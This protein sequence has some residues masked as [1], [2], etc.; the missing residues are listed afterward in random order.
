[1]MEYLRF[2]HLMRAQLV[3]AGLMS[4]SACLLLPATLPAASFQGLGALAGGAYFYSRPSDISADGHVIVG[5]SRSSNGVEAFRWTAT[6]AMVGLG[7]LGGESFFSTAFGVSANGSV[8]VGASRSSTSGSRAEA[9]RWAAATGMVGLGDLPGGDY[10][11][12]A[13]GVSGDGSVV[14][15]SS[16]SD[17]SPSW[18]E[19]FRWTEATGLVGLGVLPGSEIPTSVTWRIS[20]DGRVVVGWASTGNGRE[21]FRWTD[22]EGMI[23]MGDLPGALFDSWATGVSADGSVIVGLA[24]GEGPT[25]FRWTAATGMVDLGKPPGASGS[26]VWGVSADGGVV[27]GDSPLAGDIVPIIWDESHG[28]R[29]LVDVLV[30]LG[31]G[32]EMA[33]WDLEQATAVSAD[34]LTVVGWG[35][36][37]AGDE[38]AWVANLGQPSLVEIPTASN[39]ALALFG[40]LLAAAGLA[41]LRLR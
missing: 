28:M 32:P 19:A 12:G 40:A 31:L 21:A 2:S 26:E 10:S 17:D 14:A 22:S 29:N 30:E 15:G 25:S 33:G 11:S 1:M 24:H 35:Y 41:A 13:S 23:G 6:T 4:S 27:V 3:I 38:E 5:E 36:N 9:F 8:V 16:T 39:A 20:A 34:G 18:G 7:D 37:P